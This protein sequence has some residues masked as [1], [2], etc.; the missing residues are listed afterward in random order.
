MIK[1]SIKNKIKKWIKFRIKSKIPNN[2]LKMNKKY[3]IIMNN[4]FQ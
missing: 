1:K 2:K 3:L 4:I